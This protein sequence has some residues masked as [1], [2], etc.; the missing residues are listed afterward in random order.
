MVNFSVSCV[1]PL[2]ADLFW[3]IRA[4]PAFLAFLTSDGI[5]AEIGVT[6]PAGPSDRGPSW[7][8]RHVS[9][10][11]ANVD[12][13]RAV[14]ALVG[15]AG[16]RVTDVQV[17][18]ERG[19]AAVAAESEAAEGDEQHGVG[20]WVQEFRIRPG[21]LPGVTKTEGTLC[22]R[23][24]GASVGSSAFSDDASES[25]GCDGYDGGESSESSESS[26]SVSEDSSVA[27]SDG[28]S[29]GEDD[30]DCCEHVVTGEA[31]VLVPTLGWFVERAI[32][33]NLRAFY[34]KYPETVGRFREWMVEK[35][36]A[37][38]AGMDEVVDRMLAAEG[39]EE[40]TEGVI[41]VRVEKDETEVD[42]KE[43]VGS[44]DLL[45]RAGG[46]E[47]ETLTPQASE[48]ALSSLSGES[49]ERVTRLV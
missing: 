39:E 23:E 34:V 26:E 46:V 49:D 13:P 2:R 28:R 42:A 38:G 24:C 19:D 32:V 29:R 15:D 14:R 45:K 7:R 10:L 41:E 35:Y 47:I 40:V 36:G 48:V 1:L 11:P 33:H 21:F 27:E 30:R 5:L 37:D 17:W 6:R 43:E 44:G 8:T 16:F 3:R 4:C 31:R 12:V 20:E 25:D 9:Y 22:V 18:E